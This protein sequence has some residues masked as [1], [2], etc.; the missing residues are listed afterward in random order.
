MKFVKA[1]VCLSVLLALSACGETETVESHLTSAKT[2]L[3]QDK[4]N[5]SII[6]LKNAI[7]T[8]V[9]N[10]EARFL[11]GQVYLNL[12][13]GVAAEKELS[14]AKSLG[15]QGKELIPLL[16]RAFILT[17]ADD[18][19]IALSEQASALDN[20]QH[21]HFLAYK[22]LASLRNENVELAKETVALA[23]S[24]TAQGKYSLLAKAYLKLAENENEDAEALVQ[25]VLAIDNTQ[26]DTLMLQGQIATVMK[27]YSL[28]SESF[29]QYIEQQPRSGIVQLLLADSLLKA[30]ENEEA[31]KLA[32][33]ILARV[34][35]QPFALYIKAMVRFEA[36]DYRVAS[37]LAER[38]LSNNFNQFSLKLVAGASAFYL[39]NW[40]Q[41]YYHLNSIVK[42][43]PKEHQARRML[44]VSQLELGL[45]D[46]IS[47]TLGDIES[48]N[49]TDAQFLSSLS[50]K[51]LELGATEEAKKLL[52][53]SQSKESSDATQNARQG[54]LKLMMNDPSGMQDLKEAVQI[55]PE[56]VEAELALAYA[57]LQTND[58]EQAKNIAQKWQDKYPDKAGGFNLMASV[59]IKLEEFAQAEQLLEQSLAKEDNNLFALTEQLRIARIQKDDAL[60]KQRVDNLINL[61]PEH[62]KALRHY[63]GIYKNEKALAKL[64]A[65]YEA[66]PKELQKALL[67][68]EALLTLKQAKKA[69][70]VLVNFENDNK[71]P[72]RYWQVAVLTYKQ[73]Q[74]QTKEQ[75]T[76]EKWMK[77]SPYHIEPVILLA[78]SYANQRNYE[79]ALNIVNR[80]YEHHPDNL[81]LQMVN[82]QLLLNSKQL[83]PSKELYQTLALRDI[84]ENLKQGFLGRILMLEGKFVQAVPKMEKLYQ[85]YANSQNAIYLAAA[86]MGNNDRDKAQNHL[87]NYIKTNPNDA[88]VKALLANLYLGDNND[89]ALGY[90]ADLIK[91]QPNNVLVNNNLAWLYLEQGE[92]D[93]ALLHAEA[94]IKYGE[95]IPNVLDTYAKIL[96]KK[97]DLAGA[98][99][100]SSKASNL[101]KG[102]DVDIEL[103]YAEILIANSQQS[104]ARKV[105]NDL[106]TVTPA[107]NEKKAQLVKRL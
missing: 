54:I 41:S 44:A 45:V 64:A 36:T 3:S 102:Q 78:D 55:N 8:D 71:L 42:Y 15:Y 105:I 25:K 23:E 82:M 80:G 52:A 40:E 22:T 56:F 20:E 28:A 95:K 12:G 34:T 90:Y 35:N 43:L 104:E 103:N 58:V 57:A 47:T 17:E 88:R 74:E 100:Q 1:T 46:E 98:L 50:F 96:L 99:K 19:V 83:Q 62:N 101:A 70:S 53:Q 89:K 27:N 79:R 30:G 6:A 94:A 24:L 69:Q 63:F 4:V 75:S 2:Y 16:A 14:R 76:L 18:D 10:A 32:D 33:A 5:E 106:Q 39:N 7:R 60:S 72:K 81:I 21:S 49:D 38:A 61:Y 84:E 65:A 77:Q 97:G 11:L 9:K 66:E 31:E 13:D 91:S 26:A 85:A 92:L 37:E 59:H 86:Y 68:S 51:L 87:A 73:L 93:K 67:Y 29:K 107:Q 48:V